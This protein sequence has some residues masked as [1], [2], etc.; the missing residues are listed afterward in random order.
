MFEIER[1]SKDFQFITIGYVEGY[2]TTTEP[3]EYSYLDNT[4]RTGIHFYRLK[5]IDFDGQ[6]EYSEEIEIDV[7]GPLTFDLEQNYPNPFNPGTNIKFSLPSTNYSTLKIYNTLGEEVTVLLNKELI[8]GTYEIEWDASGVPS[9]VYFYQLKT[10]G[11][12]EIK[13]MILLK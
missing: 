8:A 7:I 11:F 10:K 1:R 3:Q 6:Y 9:G 5:Q 2:G 4:V 12:V 13:K